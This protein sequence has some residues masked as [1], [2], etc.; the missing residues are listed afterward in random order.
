MGIHPRLIDAHSHFDDVSFEADR[1]E[2][3]QRAHEAGV[4]EQVIPAVKA[5]WWP[6]IK[7]LCEQTRGLYPSYGLHPMYHSDHLEEHLTQLQEWVEK[8]QPVAIGECGLDFF[9]EDPQPQQQRYYF[10]QQL[11]IAV[12]QGLP[13]IIHARRS[14]EEVINTLRRYAG[15]Q[16]M[17]HSFSGSEQ[18][19]R[20]LVDMGFYLSFGGPI[21]YERAKRLHRLIKSLPLEAILLETDSPDQP[22][23]LH[24]G[25]RNEPAYLAE[26]LDTV[27]RL[28][29][30]PAELIAEQTAANTR[31]LFKIG[32]SPTEF[33]TRRP[34]TCC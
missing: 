4:L 7:Q 5:E 28:R 22:A 23:S 33:L 3:L 19:A 8:E 9:I 18:Q 30:Q 21:T 15:L 13:V 14:L 34:N 32:S 20:R 25:Q 29:Q 24:R 12:E 16:G 11:K 27:A 2:A 17:V 10:E 31:R 6:R 1:E 26:I